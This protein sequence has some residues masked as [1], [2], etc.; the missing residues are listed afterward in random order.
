MANTKIKRR[1]SNRRKLI[2]KN[3]LKK[4]R[5]GKGPYAKPIKDYKD[6]VLKYVDKQIDE[7]ISKRDRDNVKLYRNGIKEHIRTIKTIP[8]GPLVP[9]SDYFD[10]L[11]QIRKWQKENKISDSTLGLDRETL[12]YLRSAMD[13]KEFEYYEPE[14]LSRSSSFGSVVSDLGHAVEQ[15]TLGEGKKKRTRRRPKRKRRKSRRN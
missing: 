15:T 8:R 12:N 5:L 6:T 9:D 3:T 1:N 11:K 4:L 7:F 10:Y 14:S 2:K 13:D